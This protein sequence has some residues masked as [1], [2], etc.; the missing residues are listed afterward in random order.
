MM[1]IF[2]EISKAKT[3]R[4]AESI[5]K[6]KAKTIIRTQEIRSNPVVY[7]NAA[8]AVRMGKAEEPS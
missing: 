8:D 1:D 4:Q 5:P 2:P 7:K 6:Q 3:K